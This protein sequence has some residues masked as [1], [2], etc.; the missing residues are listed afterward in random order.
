[1]IRQLLKSS[2]MFSKEENIEFFPI[3][4]FQIS[5]GTNFQLKLTF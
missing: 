4:I 5:L 3:E 2:E 1:M